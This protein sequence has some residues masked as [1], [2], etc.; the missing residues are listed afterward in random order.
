MSN[1]EADKMLK[2][3]IKLKHRLMMP[4]LLSPDLSDKKSTH[5]KIVSAIMPEWLD[6][7]PT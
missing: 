6:D 4:Y 3:F 1:D 2:E 5:Y 7:Y